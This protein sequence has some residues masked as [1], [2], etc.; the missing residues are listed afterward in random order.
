MLGFLFKK[1]LYHMSLVT[2]LKSD[3]VHYLFMLLVEESNLLHYSLLSRSSL[4][5]SQMHC[6]KITS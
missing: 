1:I 2:F 5:P 4:K 6:Y 3:A